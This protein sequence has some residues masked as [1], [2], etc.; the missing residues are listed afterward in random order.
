MTSLNVISCRIRRRGKLHKKAKGNA[1]IA[2]ADSS[3]DSDVL[4][5]YARCAKVN[6]AFVLDFVCLFHI[7]IN[8]DYFLTYEFDHS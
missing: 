4:L 1:S 8:R 2:F 5:A 3:S 6:D 7:C